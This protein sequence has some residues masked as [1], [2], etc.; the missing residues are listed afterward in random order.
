MFGWSFAYSLVKQQPIPRAV[1]DHSQLFEYQLYTLVLPKSKKWI[2]LPANMNA[3]DWLMVMHNESCWNPSSPTYIKLQINELT[4]VPKDDGFRNRAT[5]P[6]E[7]I[8]FDKTNVSFIR[9]LKL[10][11]AP[12][13]HCAICH[14]VRLKQEILLLN[15]LERDNNHSLEAGSICAD[16]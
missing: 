9:S 10:K 16:L 5:P 8:I 2:Q 14:I 3:F 12:P 15:N 1:L 7:T 6:T 11:K 4:I 13:T